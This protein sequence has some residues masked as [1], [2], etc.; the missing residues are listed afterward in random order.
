MKK[1]ILAMLVIAQLLMFTYAYSAE[2]AI[3]HA[4]YSHPQSGLIE[5]AGNNPA[6]GQAMVENVAH[7]LALIEEV[8]GQLY[9]CLRLNMANY[10]SGVSFASQAKGAA[11]FY[12]CDYQIVQESATTTDY[13]FAV[14]AKDAVI[15]VSCYIEEMARQVIF[16]ISFSDF[17]SGN[18]DFIALGEN[19]QLNDVVKSSLNDNGA[20]I[21]LQAVN[22]AMSVDQLGYDH[23]LLLKDSP[24]I[25]ALLAVSDSAQSDRQTQTNQSISTP[26]TDSSAQ[27]WGP[28][29]TMVLAGLLL[30]LVLLT[31]FFS[32]LAIL[33]FGL[34]RYLKRRNDLA[35]EA[36]YDKD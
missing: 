34:A 7:N 12:A 24:Q 14:P 8:N 35:E 10:I 19:G 28:L 2:T 16:Y 22:T 23:G 33:L 21:E 30:F 1:I 36:I 11:E 4:H 6:I 29:T 25:K 17:A 32:A 15:R 13:R 18:S 3:V 9:V 26:S 27:A 31:F 20:M 5:D